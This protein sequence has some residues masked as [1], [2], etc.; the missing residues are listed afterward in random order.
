MQLDYGNAFGITPLSY[1][2]FMNYSNLLNPMSSR[3]KNISFDMLS[4]EGDFT[5][6]IL[7]SAP[8][9]LS[10]SID[11]PSMGLLTSLHVT[12]KQV[13]NVLLPARW[14]VVSVHYHCA[15][16]SLYMVR[17]LVPTWLI[18]SAV[19]YVRSA[20]QLPWWNFPYYPGR[21]DY[22]KTAPVVS[23]YL[24]RYDVKDHPS[25]DSLEEDGVVS[26]IRFH[27]GNPQCKPFWVGE[28]AQ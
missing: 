5:L 9:I 25:Q 6:F 13:S 21:D 1:V 27:M 14:Y 4:G 11:G 20:A 12:F 7:F 15:I 28:M 18:S 26:S 19:D 10:L 22:P 8:R 24:A 16:F 17:W 2:L 23:H 3:A